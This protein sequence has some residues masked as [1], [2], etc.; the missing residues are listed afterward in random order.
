VRRIADGTAFADGAD[1]L[2]D[3]TGRLGETESP[4]DRH[5]HSDTSARRQSCRQIPAPSC[6]GSAHRD[7]RALVDQGQRAEREHAGQQI[8]AEQVKQNEADREEDGADQR[9]AGLHGDGDGEG[10]GKIARMAPAM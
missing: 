3:G 4:D 6:A 7:A 5:H 10:C 8:E 9:L 2:A 1:L